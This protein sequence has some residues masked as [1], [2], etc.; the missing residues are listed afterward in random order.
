ML[1]LIFVVLVD[2]CYSGLIDMVALCLTGVVK[3]AK[4]IRNFT[5][6]EVQVRVWYQL[7]S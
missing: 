2:L 3:V 1:I 7:A 4:W 6:E 5:S